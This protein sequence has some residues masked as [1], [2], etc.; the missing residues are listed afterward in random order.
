MSYVNLIET[1]KQKS[2]QKTEKKAKHA[3][4]ENQ[5]KKTT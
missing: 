2:A 3:T 1:T 5:L 4:T